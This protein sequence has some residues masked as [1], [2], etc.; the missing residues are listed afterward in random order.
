MQ[1]NDLKY[2]Q[3]HKNNG[4]TKIG[5]ISPNDNSTMYSLRTIEG[6]LAIA[7]LLN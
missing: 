7:D 3:Y 2:W 1:I 4:I 5:V 6:S